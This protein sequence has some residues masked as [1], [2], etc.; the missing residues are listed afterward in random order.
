MI[1]GQRVQRDV[2]DGFVGQLY[3]QYATERQIVIKTDQLTENMIAV[4]TSYKVPFNESGLR[5][6]PH[7]NVSASWEVPEE[8]ARVILEKER[9]A[10]KIWELGRIVDVGTL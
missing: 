1:H 4:L 10:L 8:C 6:Y 5:R 2:P 3:C 9:E 7:V